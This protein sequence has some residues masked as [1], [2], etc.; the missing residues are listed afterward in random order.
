MEALREFVVP[1]CQKLLKRPKEGAPVSADEIVRW[2]LLPPGGRK[3]GKFWANRIYKTWTL[4]EGREALRKRLG[5]T[6]L[7]DKELEDR[8]DTLTEGLL[9]APRVNK[10]LARDVSEAFERHRRNEKN[11]VWGSLKFSEITSGDEARSRIEAAA[12]ADGWRGSLA[13]FWNAHDRIVSAIEEYGKLGEEKLVLE[14]LGGLVALL[15]TLGFFGGE[16]SYHRFGT[17][18]PIRTVNDKESVHTEAG[19]VPVGGIRLVAVRPQSNGCSPKPV[20]DN[21]ELGFVQLGTEAVDPFSI[22]LTNTDS[23]DTVH[24]GRDEKWLAWQSCL[25]VLCFSRSVSN[26][27]ARIIRRDGCWRV[28]DVGS[29]GHGS[30]NGTL[31]IRAGTGKHV[32]L[33]GGQPVDLGDGDLLCLAPHQRADGSHVPPQNGHVRSFLVQIVD[34]E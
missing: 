7:D 12:R 5:V 22:T 16:G 14:Y 29:N 6:L 10:A 32:F 34:G 33:K 2:Y 13:P 15:V 11:S 31:V 4:A 8:L 25:P 28:Q 30:L 21:N 24:F 27:H 26:R 18:S 19:K 17:E 9:D 20:L 3:A 23:R 1:F